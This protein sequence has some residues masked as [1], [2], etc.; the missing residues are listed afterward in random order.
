MAGTASQQRPPTNLLFVQKHDLFIIVFFN[1]KFHKAS[2]LRKMLPYIHLKK[3]KKKQP[4]KKWLGATTREYFFRPRFL[5]IFYY[6]FFFLKHKKI[7][8]KRSTKATK[9]VG[10]RNNTIYIQPKS[11][12]KKKKKE[13][14]IRTYIW[15]VSIIQLLRP[16]IT[17]SL[18]WSW[19]YMFK[20]SNIIRCDMTHES[21][22]TM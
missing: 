7:A 6:Y 17:F 2:D 10:A 14:N 8:K 16:K 15:C 12:K 3:K 20:S 13:I 4:K 22:M 18:F 11:E 21:I 1:I 5:F 9:H 19:L